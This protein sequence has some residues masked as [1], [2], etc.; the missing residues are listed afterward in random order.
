METDNL[1][2]CYIISIVLWW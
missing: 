1:T 2:N